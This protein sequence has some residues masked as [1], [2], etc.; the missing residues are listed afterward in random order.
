MIIWVPLP[1]SSLNVRVN[2]RVKPFRLNMSQ[3]HRR[4]GGQGV[5]VE[6]EVE[7]EV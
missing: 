1:K 5:E 4:C 7:V 3:L 2:L 6:V